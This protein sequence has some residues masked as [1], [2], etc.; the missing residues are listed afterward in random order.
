M[1]NSKEGNFMAETGRIHS[2][3]TCGTVDGPGIR[4]VIFF[5]GCP[6]RCRYCH[7]PDTWDRHKGQEITIPELLADIGDYKSFMDYSG[8]G[9]TASGGEPLMQAEFVADLFAACQKRSIHTALDTSGYTSL[10]KAKRLLS[11]T[12]LVLLDIKSYNP[13]TFQ[14]ISSVPIEPV[15]NFL[16]YLKSKQIPAW[17]RFVLVPGLSDHKPDIQQMA[18]YL[19]G[20]SNIERID[21]LPFHKIG[22]YKWKELGYAYDLTDT[23]PPSS[24]ELTDVK[25]IFQNYGFQV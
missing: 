2:I 7:N 25:L 24:Q 10:E 23:Q 9:V 8:G 17:I 3:E 21:V 1:K 18:A 15:I 12:N 11:Y 16:E 13:Q 5:Q 14:H 20:F 6:L 4:Y 19:K 22:E